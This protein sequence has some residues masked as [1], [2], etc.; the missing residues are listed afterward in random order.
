MPFLPS[1]LLCHSFAS[2]SSRRFDSILI[3]TWTRH[4]TNKKNILKTYF[5]FSFFKFYFSSCFT[6]K[7]WL[8]KGVPDSFLAHVC[9]AF[10]C[11]EVSFFE[12]RDVDSANVVSLQHSGARWEAHSTK[13]ANTPERTSTTRNIGEVPSMVK[14]SIQRSYR[15][16]YHSNL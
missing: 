14:C 11:K 9:A 7:S 10:R 4:E 8:I 3:V 15:P 1:P 5:S 16:V 2:L 6:N 13:L 12:R